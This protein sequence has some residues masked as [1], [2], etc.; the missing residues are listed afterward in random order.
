MELGYATSGSS[1]KS[2]WAFISSCKLLKDTSYPSWQ[3]ALK[4]THMLLGY[5]SNAVGSPPDMEH[6]ADRLT[7]MN[8]FPKEKMGDAY[9]HTYVASDG[10]HDNN[11]CRIIAEDDEVYNN[12]WIDFYYPVITI[13]STKVIYDCHL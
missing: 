10:I 3:E 7:G 11:W 1:G 4:G 2:I 9:F 5:K 12:D 6:L 8:G 13:D